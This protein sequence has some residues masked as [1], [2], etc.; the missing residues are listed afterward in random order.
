MISYVLNSQVE[1]SKIKNCI[2]MIAFKYDLLSNTST[3]L[4]KHVLCLNKDVVIFGEN[5][6]F[7]AQL[8]LELWLNN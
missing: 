8:F 3:L 5:F 1:V 6:K 4:K 7:L 2:L